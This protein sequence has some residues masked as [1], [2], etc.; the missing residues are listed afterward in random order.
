MHPVARSKAVWI[1]FLGFSLLIV[2]LCLL[3][4]SLR[5]V[6]RGGSVAYMSMQASPMYI[7][8]VD[9][10]GIPLDNTTN[11][12][13]LCFDLRVIIWVLFSYYFVGGCGENCNVVKSVNRSPIGGCSESVV[14]Q[15]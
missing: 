1:C 2:C 15:L 8:P 7:S 6:G 9:T 11:Q 4:C 10:G 14:V 5:D 13:L 12:H 3:V